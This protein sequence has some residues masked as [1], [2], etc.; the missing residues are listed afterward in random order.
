MKGIE[1][2]SKG[3]HIGV[4]SLPGRKNPLLYKLED[5]ALT[6]LASFK[7]EEDAE[8]F[9]DILENMADRINQLGGTA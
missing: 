1:L 6:V 8:W 2:R 5:G 3:Y 4:G 7:K 9:R